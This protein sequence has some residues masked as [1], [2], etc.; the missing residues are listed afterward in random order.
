M[1]RQRVVGRRQSRARERKANVLAGV[2]CTSATSCTAAGHRDFARHSSS[3]T[4]DQSSLGTCACYPA[5]V[6]MYAMLSTLG[7]DGWETLRQ[8]PERILAVRS[9]VEALG[10]KVHAQ[11]ALM[12]QY[13][14]LNLIEAPDEQT[15][16]KAAIML[17]ARGTMRTTT[18]PAIPV[19]DLIARLSPSNAARSLDPPGAAAALFAEIVLGEDNGQDRAV[20][21]AAHLV[22]AFADAVVRP[23]GDFES[24][25]PLLR[26]GSG[27][28]RGCRGS[29]I[30]RTAMV[31]RHSGREVIVNPLRQSL[32]PLMRI[33]TFRAVTAPYPTLRIGAEVLGGG[34][35]DRGRDRRG[36]TRLVGRS[37]NRCRGRARRRSPDG[38]PRLEAAHARRA[39][40]RA[41]GYAAGRAASASGTRP[42]RSATRS[43]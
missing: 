22:H 28:R 9:E 29:P 26:N 21:T 33:A 37:G 15:M 43:A 38:R 41:G 17:A 31:Q 25:R 35:P 34:R 2:S 30:H 5:R 11:Y 23:F 18:L 4:P 6:P 19:D 1:E 36:R 16:A 8:H 40:G 13:D 3:G 12:G 39:R 42:T 7:P 20:R 24:A 27:L 32:A 14:F 10:L